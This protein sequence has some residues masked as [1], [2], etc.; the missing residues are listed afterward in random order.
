MCRLLSTITEYL[1]EQAANEA[2]QGSSFSWKPIRKETCTL[3]RCPE[4]KQ[5]CSFLLKFLEK[6]IKPTIDPQTCKPFTVEKNPEEHEL[7]CELDRVAASS[8]LTREEKVTLISVPAPKK[9]G[10]F[11]RSYMSLSRV[12]P[13]ILVFG[14]ILLQRFLKTTGWTLRASNWRVIFMVVMRIAQK[15]ENHPIVMVS[16]MN[17]MYSIYDKEDFI[18]LENVLLRLLDYK[19]YVNCEEYK[20]IV[21]IMLDTTSK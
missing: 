11:V 10:E 19:C 14:F 21:E 8:T 7:F 15:Y 5:L 6:E 2:A 9:I 4:K 12:Q 3:E 13:E 17:L 18:E 1:E 16:D 20:E